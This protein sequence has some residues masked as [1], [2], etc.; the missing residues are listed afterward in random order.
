MG[1]CPCVA[2]RSRRG[3]CSC[4]LTFSSRLRSMP[5]RWR[6]WRRRCHLGQRRTRRTLRRRRSARYVTATSRRS[7]GR[8]CTRREVPLWTRMTRMTALVLVG[9]ACNARSSKCH[10]KKNRPFFFKKKKKKKIPLFLKKKKKKKK[11][12]S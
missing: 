9:S 7:C 1:V 6:H 4:A 2:R 3:R 12:K 10:E 8:S 5:T 11:K